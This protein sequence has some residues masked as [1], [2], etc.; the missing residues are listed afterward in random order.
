MTSLQTQLQQFHELVI[1]K[2]LHRIQI[3]K[4]FF[5]IV[6]GGN[7]VFSYFL[8]HGASKMTP[9][10]YVRA[11]LKEVVRFT[12]KIY[13]HGGRKIVFF[14]IGPIGCIPGRVLLRNASIDKCNDKMDAMTRYYNT[15]LKRFILGI[16]RMYPGAIGVYA[17]SYDTSKKYRENPKIYGTSSIT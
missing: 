6:S 3:S 17:A 11:M 8:F 13:L 10:T 14:S 7:D 4:S 2:H 12:S 16:P 1:H 15:G 5:F 9:R